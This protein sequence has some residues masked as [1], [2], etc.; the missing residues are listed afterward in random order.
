VP[1][2]LP[3]PVAVYR[4]ARARAIDLVT[5][6]DLDT[7]DGCLEVL[8]RHPEAAGTD[9]MISV[10]V[11][12][13]D[14]RTGVRLHVLLY[15]LSESQHREA[16]R[17]KGDVGD[18]AA[19]ARREGIVA[20]LGSLGGGLRAAGAAG[21]RLPE[22]LALFDRF[23]IKNGAVGRRQN[24][25]MARLAREA[26]GGRTFGITAGSNA[27]DP[28][29]IGRTLTVSRATARAGFVE[30]L[31]Q[32]RTWATGEDGGWRA[33]SADIGRLIA[34]GY[35]TRPAAHALLLPLHLTAA[36]FLGNCVRH[37]WTDARARR[38]K[39]RL[40]HLVVSRFKDKART[41]AT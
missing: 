10:E 25:L 15:D 18:L 2:G 37:A 36:P 23:E 11:R 19:Y 30:D 41:Y 4:T 34:R 20:S 1:A 12:A 35:R 13:R 16:Q 39:R 14:P 40:D 5:L 38:A 33:S 28:A 17:L 29:R 27:H 7:I 26:T 21:G 24:D 9:F 8:G 31:R 32:H 6:T 22:F 3:D